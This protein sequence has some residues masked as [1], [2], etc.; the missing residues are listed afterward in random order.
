MSAALGA[1]QGFASR[2]SLL[3]TAMPVPAAAAAQ[4]QMQM[5]QQMQAAPGM[6]Q[7]QQQPVLYAKAVPVQGNTAGENSSRCAV[8][9]VVIAVWA[10]RRPGLFL[11]L[12][13]TDLLF[14]MQ[15]LPSR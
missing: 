12:S 11:K 2:D 7:E 9:S 8:P 10:G 4:M 6:Q 5:A 15:Q 13:A 1:V 3:Q 14:V